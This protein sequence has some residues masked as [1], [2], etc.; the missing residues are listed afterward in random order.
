ME[1]RVLT[2]ESLPEI[3]SQTYNTD[4]KPDW[5]NLYPYYHPDIVF[6]D[7]I[8]KF[9]GFEHFTEMCDRLTKRCDQLRFDIHDIVQDGNIIF[10]EW[11]MTMT[12]RRTPMTPMHGSSKFTLHEDGRIL[13]QRDYYDLWGGFLSTDAAAAR[14]HP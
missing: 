14:P 5:S 12:F 11:T 3:W 7:S 10:L 13:R 4:G 2:P 6:H 1:R 8:Q 9:E